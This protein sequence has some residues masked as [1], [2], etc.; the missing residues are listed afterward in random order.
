M[1]SNKTEKSIMNGV[2]TS[3]IKEIGKEGHGHHPQLHISWRTSFSKLN[4]RIPDTGKLQIKKK[5]FQ[6]SIVL[7]EMLTLKTKYLFPIMMVPN[8]WIGRG[9]RILSSSPD[10]TP[11]DFLHLLKKC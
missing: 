10:M 5:K 4:Q 11:F 8:G 3:S 7:S 9:G 2:T 1:E 6:V